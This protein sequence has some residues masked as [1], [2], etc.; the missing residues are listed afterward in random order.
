MSARP[1]IISTL[2]LSACVGPLE[3]ESPTSGSVAAADAN[4]RFVTPVVPVADHHQNLLSPAGVALVNRPLL[5]PI[6]VPA[7]VAAVLS[8]RAEAT[9]D[10][11]ALASIFA[12]DAVFLGP[13]QAGGWIKG[14]REAAKF[15]SSIFSP[16]YRLTPTIFTNRGDV[17]EVAGY[18]TRGEGTALRH[19]GYFNM[20]L[21]KDARPETR[22]SRHDQSEGAVT[23]TGGSNR[24]ALKSYRMSC[25]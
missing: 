13:D 9:S 8:R 12:E 17:A 23:R 16:G 2:M 10:V 11:P 7:P 3:I 24:L 25:V 4:G 20:T 15:I 14:G 19:P 22:R 18:Y 6:H 5:Q 1:L 21:A